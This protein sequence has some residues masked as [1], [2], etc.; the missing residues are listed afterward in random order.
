MLIFVFFCL[1]FECI[2]CFVNAKNAKCLK[3]L[4]KIFKKKLGN[5]KIQKASPHLCK[6][7]ELI[8]NINNMN[9]QKK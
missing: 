7:F 2:F 8:D 4:L 5:F 3:I 6:R 1:F 9:Q